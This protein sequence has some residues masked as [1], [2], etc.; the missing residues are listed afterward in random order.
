LSKFHEN[1][2]NT[3]VYLTN[4]ILFISNQ[5]AYSCGRQIIAIV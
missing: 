5:Q 1:N 2:F 4:S 3:T